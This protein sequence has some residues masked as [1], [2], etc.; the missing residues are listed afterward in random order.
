MVYAEKYQK[1]Q[2]G[3]LPSLEDLTTLDKVSF[4]NEEYI[5]PQLNND[6][7]LTDSQCFLTSPMV[8]GYALTTK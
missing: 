7:L 4:D 2:L 1:E 3:Y 5:V 8:K 6:L